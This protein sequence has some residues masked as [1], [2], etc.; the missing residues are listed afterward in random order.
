MGK[1]VPQRGER[2]PVRSAD[3]QKVAAEKEHDTDLTVSEVKETHS[4]ILKLNAG[5]KIGCVEMGRLL[6]VMCNRRVKGR[7]E[8]RPYQVLGYDNFRDYCERAFGMLRTKS[9]TLMSLAQHADEGILPTKEVETIGWSKVERLLPLIKSGVITK[10]NVGKWLKK[11]E[12]K[13][14]DEVKGMTKM[15]Q[16]K[17]KAKQREKAGEDEEEEKKGSVT[18]SSTTTT[19]SST[20]KSV[21]LEEEMPGDDMFTLRVTLMKDQWENAQ[22]ALKK[23]KTIT[24]S[25]KLPW[26]LDCIFMAFNSEGFSKKE[27]A[28]DEMC[29]R[30]ERVFN[31]DII[32]MHS[33]SKQI[34]FGQD[35]A[36]ALDIMEKKA[37]KT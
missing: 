2:L 6:R 14:F 7:L 20:T 30:I 19:K 9:Y 29:R 12:D 26:L 22:I 27:Q 16:E 32:A 4:R 10:N 1:K 8:E 5:M 36:K 31:V 25:E 23:A 17:A 33:K 37:A 3:V 11:I 34:A 18:V 15:A 35:L 13:N 21:K 28:L 24:G